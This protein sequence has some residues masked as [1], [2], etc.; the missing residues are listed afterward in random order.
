[1]LDYN[2]NIILINTIKK[3][4]KS[5][6]KEISYGIFKLIYGQIDKFEFKSDKLKV[7]ISK[8]QPDINYK[9]Y[10]VEDSRI[11]TDT[12]HDTGVIH[13]NKILQGPSFQIRNTKFHPIEENTIL[14]NGTPRLIKKLK[15]TVFSLLTGGAGNFNYWHWLF[16]VLPRLRI[17][18][19]SYNLDKID[20]FLFPNLNQKFQKE[21]LDLLNIPKEKRLS[22]IKCRHIK[23]NLII[24]TDHP[25]VLKNDAS[26]EIQNFP[27][28]M[29]NWLRASFLDEKVMP[30][31]TFPKKIYIDRG[32][33]KS[34]HREYRKIIN[35]QEIINTLRI[36]GYQP[37]RL[38]ELSF[39][40]QVKTFYNAEKIIGL[41]GAGFANL[42]FCRPKT[43]I[44]EIKPSTDGK[45]I[46]NLAIK[47]N[48]KFKCVSKK[49]LRHNYYGNT[50]HLEVEFSEIQKAFDL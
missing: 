37:I 30:D 42:I 45:V 35:E 47:S 49:P 23:A 19:N 48:L 25:Y 1:M 38:A 31:R 6:F 4:L 5:I 32:D 15:G 8:F 11:Y 43:Q 16:D 28:W 36:E 29:Q 46:E 27:N 21:S 14:N 3:K 33:A 13:N 34:N 39:T 7:S 20:Y 18:E 12:I 24:T 44:L 50:G 22:S 2:Y 10:H 9:V 26:N 40:E 17:L 41:H